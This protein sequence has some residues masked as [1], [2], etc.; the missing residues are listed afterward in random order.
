[1]FRNLLVGVDGSPTAQRALTE[2]IDLALASNARLT[3]L[4]AI[5]PLPPLVAAASAIDIGRLEREVEDES[6]A[7]LRAAV[8]RVPAEIPVTHRLARGPAGEA[9][10]AEVAA[11]GH[12]LVVLGS[13]GRGRMRSIA[14]GSTGAHVH[15]HASAALLVVHSDPDE[16]QEAAASHPV[17]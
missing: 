16:D 6:A 1:V 9:I 17:G 13:R 7:I 5:P 11:R 2:A 14:L 12:D 4:V 8:D 10:V 15:Y 3:I